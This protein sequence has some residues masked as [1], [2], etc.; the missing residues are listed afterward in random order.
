MLFHAP[1]ADPYAPT[2]TT[3]EDEGAARARNL[4]RPG[5]CLDA[6]TPQDATAAALAYL[7]DCHRAGR[8]GTTRTTRTETRPAP[9]GEP[10][11]VII[12]DA[13]APAPTS[14][15]AGEV[16]ETIAFYATRANRKPRA[17]EG[18]TVIDTTTD[19]DAPAQDTDGGLPPA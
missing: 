8:P 15:E 5:L 6:A 16:A 3:L 10:V 4:H 19:T 2:P 1:L 12:L 17:P 14:T 11:P 18:W 9:C 13:P 7:L